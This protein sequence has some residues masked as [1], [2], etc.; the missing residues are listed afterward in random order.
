MDTHSG[1]FRRGAAS[2]QTC[3]KLGTSLQ[4]NPRVGSAGGRKIRTRILVVLQS[5][6]H[7]GETNCVLS[8]LL[9]PAG[10]LAAP[11][12]HCLSW[13]RWEGSVPWKCRL[14]KAMEE[15]EG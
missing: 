5:S 14:S 6:S 7:L 8:D 2:F 4:A 9:D 10:M 1:F 12:E 13:E 3:S 11:G 15:L